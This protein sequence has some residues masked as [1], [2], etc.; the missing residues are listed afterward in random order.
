LPT[1]L[2]LRVPGREL[3]LDGAPEE[4]RSGGQ[5]VEQL[6]VHALCVL[7]STAK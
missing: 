5:V 6:L 7:V 1:S 3:G 2:A 4:M